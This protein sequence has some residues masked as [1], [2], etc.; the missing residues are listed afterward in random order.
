MLNVVGTEVEFCVDN[1]LERHYIID[2][3]LPH[4]EEHTMEVRL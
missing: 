2:T 3:P 4:G 1:R